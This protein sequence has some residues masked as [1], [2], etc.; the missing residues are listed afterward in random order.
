MPQPKKVSVGNVIGQILMLDLVFS[1]D[2]VLTAVAMVEPA[3]RRSLRRRQS[4]SR[5]CPGRR[6]R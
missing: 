5:R 2:S 6:W 4:L 3:T 1:I